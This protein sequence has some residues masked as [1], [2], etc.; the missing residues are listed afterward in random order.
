MDDSREAKRLETATE[1]MLR[2]RE[3][4]AGED[5]LV[6]WV[7]WC[8]SDP[9]NQRAFDQVQEL[10]H[11]AGGLEAELIG[12]ELPVPRPAQQP[13]RARRWRRRLL[14][15]LAL[16]AANI[17]V[18]VG[19]VA[20]A[21]AVYT[22]R[23]Q[24]GDA[25]LV[26]AARSEP[27]REAELSD[28]STMELA[29]KSVVAVHYSAARRDIELR[30]GEAYFTVAPNKERPFVVAAG[31]VRV[32]AV[33]TA[34]NVRQ[35]GERVV[36]TVTKGKVD[37]Y[38][39]EP[40]AD[41][42]EA[43]QK[44]SVRVGPGDQVSWD[45][46]AAHDPVVAVV[47]PRLA[48]SWREGRLAYSNEPLAA[49]IADYNRYSSRPAVIGSAAVGDMR[50]SGTL[51]IDSTHEWLHALPGEFPVRLEQRNGVDVIEPAPRQP[52]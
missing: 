31:D 44:A 49:V 18:L 19:L 15:P 33:G 43:S 6:Q 34:F 7:Q 23:H 35:A 38:R 45:A 20:V 46:A 50:F 24:A 8:E 27:V 3:G 1:W 52:G 14:P 22:H 29:A 5:D 32:R 10:W 28:G 4:S 42:G 11:V 47:D 39:V 26:A 37:V 13:A 12:G 40:Q 9:L 36:V 41:G 2:L 16:A 30:Q 51:L 25:D 21:M 48:L 17:L